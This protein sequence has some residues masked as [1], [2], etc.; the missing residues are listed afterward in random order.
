MPV[1]GTCRPAIP[2]TDG[3]YSRISSGDRSRRIPVEAVGPAASLELVERGKLARLG[4]DDDLAA[5]LVRHAV[6]LD[7]AVHQVPTLDAVPRFE[8]ARLVVQ[9]R[10]DHA[11]VVA[12]LVR[13]EV[14][15][16]LQ[17]GQRAAQPLAQRVRRGDTD[18]A[19]ADDDDV[20]A[21]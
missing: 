20:V 5:A 15:L 3:S 10:V 7:Q 14:V 18:D 12:A 19:A 8:R 11:A 9:P 21:R 16:R 1:C 6:L 13:G 4:R 17:H 2:A